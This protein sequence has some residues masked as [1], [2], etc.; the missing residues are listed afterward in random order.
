M[1]A[2]SDSPV[3]SRNSALTGMHKKKFFHADI[4]CANIVALH[5]M[6]HN[7]QWVLIDCTSAIPA[8]TPFTP[9]NRPPGDVKNVN[10]AWDA[11][12]DF[13]MVANL[14]ASLSGIFDVAPFAAFS[15]VL[16]E[17]TPQQQKLNI[18]QAE[19]DSVVIN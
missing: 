2:F 4:R 16:R 6:Q 7:L 15:T 12:F 8:S 1:L 3:I 19:L 14:I 18:L 17:G 11:S 10:A 13:F 5:D 9:Y